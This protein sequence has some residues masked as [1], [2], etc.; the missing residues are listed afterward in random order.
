M[1]MFNSLPPRPEHLQKVK[2]G[3]KSGAPTPLADLVAFTGLSR[4]QALCALEHMMKAGTVEKAQGGHVYAL[5]GKGPE[6]P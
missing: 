6:T 4:T 3:L 1:T 2:R 5:T